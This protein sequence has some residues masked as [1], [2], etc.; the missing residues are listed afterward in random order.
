MGSLFDSSAPINGKH[1]DLFS[2]REVDDFRWIVGVFSGSGATQAIIKA[3]AAH[4]ATFY[5]IRFNRIGE[6]VPLYRNYLFLEFRE[7]VTIALCRSTASFIKVLSARNPDS[8]I[9][10]PVIVR[11]E[12]IHE[13]LRL[14]MSGKFNE[15]VFCRQ[16][17]G[18]GSLIKV[19]EGIFIGKNVILQ[20]DITPEMRGSLRIPVLIDGIKAIIELHKLAL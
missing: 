16:F 20:I 8:E 5:P 7:F 3:N 19:T 17:H 9:S 10:Y 13:S 18:R 14:M 4:L 12:A 2:G 6:P 1:Y 15:R 11:R